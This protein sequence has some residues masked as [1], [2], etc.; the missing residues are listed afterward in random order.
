[1]TIY[2]VDTSVLLWLNGDPDRLSQPV[3][4]LFTSDDGAYLISLASVWEMQI[5]VQLAKLRL[6]GR[7]TDVRQFI[8]DIV[9]KQS[10]FGLLPIHKEHIYAL[11]DLPSHH[12]DPFDRLLIAQSKSEQLPIITADGIFSAYSVPVIW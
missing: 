5:K 12:R 10:N 2:I 11:A 1:M 9:A 4:Q 6:P 8:E 7:S 3:R